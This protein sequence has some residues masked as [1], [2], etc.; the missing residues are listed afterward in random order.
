MEAYETRGQP[1]LELR[2]P[3]IMPFCELKKGEVFKH[4]GRVLIKTSTIELVD[5]YQ[6][7]RR[8][9]G[10]RMKVFNALRLTRQ[11]G[12]KSHISSDT[13]VERLPKAAIYTL[14]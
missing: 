14:G 1:E 9:V 8:S 6:T 4:S 5:K 10:P 2:N 12:S 11:P 3:N 13:L 7:D